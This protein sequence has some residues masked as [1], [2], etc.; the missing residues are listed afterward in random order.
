[1]IVSIAGKRT[2]TLADLAAVLATLRP[3]Q[4]VSVAIVEQNGK[5]ATIRLTLGELPG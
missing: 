2:L 1:V 3:G 4:K 5:K